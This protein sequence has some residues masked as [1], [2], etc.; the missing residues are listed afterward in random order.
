MSCYVTRKS[1]EN[2]ALYRSEAHWSVFLLLSVPSS[3]SST[4]TTVVSLSF[5]YA[6]KKCAVVRRGLTMPQQLVSH[7]WKRCQLIIHNDEGNEAH[8][9]TSGLFCHTRSWLVWEFKIKIGAYCWNIVEIWEIPL[10]F[11]VT[12]LTV[13]FKVFLYFHDTGV[14]ASLQPGLSFIN[15]HKNKSW[16][17]LISLTGQR[18]KGQ[19]A[20][21]SSVV[22][23]KLWY[24]SLHCFNTASLYRRLPLET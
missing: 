9:Q 10:P 11:S 22:A 24:A 16:V 8:F 5:S 17:A 15:V 13:K 20:G 23:G 2:G 1:S 14:V 7:K 19:P 6:N 21:M 3:A 12:C 4:F 18:C